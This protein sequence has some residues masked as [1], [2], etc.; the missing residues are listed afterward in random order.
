MELHYVTPQGAAEKL[1]TDP[2]WG[3]SPREVQKRQEKFGK[4]LVEEG[5]TGGGVL[6]FLGPFQE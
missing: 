1:G 4:I 6:R 3:L 5:R 2:Q